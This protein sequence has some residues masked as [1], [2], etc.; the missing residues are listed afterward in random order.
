MHR[1]DYLRFSI[2]TGTIGVVA[3]CAGNS[4][5]DTQTQK[6]GDAASSEQEVT[7]ERESSSEKSPTGSAAAKIEEHTESATRALDNAATKLGTE[8]DK[9]KNSE[10]EDGGVDV[11]VVGINQQ[12]DT[13]ESELETAKEYA[14]SDQIEVINSLIEVIE[15]VRKFTELID[16]FA[17]GYSETFTGYTY[18]QSQRYTDAVTQFEQ[19]ENSLTDT[20]SLLAVTWDRYESLDQVI[21]DEVDQG[22]ITE[23]EQG[24]TNFEGLLP[25]LI[26]LAEGVKYVSQGLI[27]YQQASD[28][29]DAEDFG[30]ASSKFEAAAEDF[31]A[32]Y[33]EFKTQE[34]DAPVEVKNTVIEMTCYSG[35]L[36]DGSRKLAEGTEAYEQGDRTRANGLFSEAEAAFDR[37]DFGTGATE[38]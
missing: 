35:S 31:G 12:L 33:T 2:A 19:A 11:E 15:F 13:A 38:S 14:E 3:G 21:I 27:D 6:S 5:T 23:L 1:R 24:L 28:Y 36:R 30:S 32:A 8:S 7:E 16:V 37:C 4:S 29:V 20:Q 25:V 17:E 18:F 9:F 10:F 26:T 22:N 34:E